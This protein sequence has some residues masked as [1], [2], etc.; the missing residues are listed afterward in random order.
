MGKV[1]LIGAGMRS[2]PGVAARMFRT[3]ADLDINLRMISTSPIKIS[4]M[5]AAIGWSRGR[6]RAARRILPVAARVGPARDRLRGDG[7]GRGSSVACSRKQAPR[8]R[9]RRLDR[10]RRRRALPAPVRVRDLGE[11]R[12]AQHGRIRRTRARADR[13]RRDP[14]AVATRAV[15]ELYARWTWLPSGPPSRDYKS[16]AG[17][18]AAGVRQAR[19]RSSSCAPPAAAPAYLGDLGRADARGRSCRC[20]RAA[21]TTVD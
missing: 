7:R 19:P 5:I 2:H 13:R 21:G 8:A 9:A 6:A 1:S 14:R 3:L 12:R 11:P 17:P 20:S 10:A 4:C 18:T 16:L 15:D